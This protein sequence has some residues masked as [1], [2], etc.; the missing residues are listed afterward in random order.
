MEVPVFN[1]F[2]GVIFLLLALLLLPFYLLEFLW[3]G[4]RRKWGKVKNS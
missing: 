3:E 1:K 4:L 2:W